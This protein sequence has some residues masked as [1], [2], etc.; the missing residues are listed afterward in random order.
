MKQ[1]QVLLVVLLVLVFNLQG[2]ADQANAA[3]KRGT[4]AEAQNEYEQAYDAYNQAHTLKPKDANYYAAYLRLRFYVAVQDVRDGQE[5][6]DAGKLQEALA[7]FNRAADV[8]ETNFYAKE[9]ARRTEEMIRRRQAARPDPASHPARFRPGRDRPAGALLQAGPGPLHRVRAADRRQ[10]GLGPRRGQ[11]LPRRRALPEEE[12]PRDL[13]QPLQA[14]ARDRAEEARRGGLAACARRQSSSASP[15]LRRMRIRCASSR[16]TQTCSSSSARS[17]R[18]ACTAVRS[19]DEGFVIDSPVLPHELEALPQVLEQSGFPVSGLLATHGD[20]DH[21]L[22]R[23]AFPEAS[24]G[25][26]REH[27]GAPGRRSASCLSASSP[28]STTST[29]SS[30]RPALALDQIQH[31]PVPGH[32]ALGA[33]GH[34]LE[35]HP[36]PGHTAD[37]TAYLIPWLGMLVCGDYLSPVEIP[38]ISAGGSAEAYLETLE[39]LQGL[40]PRAT[41]HRAGSRRPDRPRRRG[42]L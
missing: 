30:D 33:N 25:L 41:H 20:W 18:P 29:T 1:L 10:E 28:S 21:L 40:L 23:H 15:R 4:H 27:C 37:G 22:G 3:Y 5:L 36:A 34:E 32:L 17:G 38:W 14:A 35:L 39:R 31:L 13:G 8:D 24:L 26:R 16:S 9:E 6:R 42:A 12:D 2:Y 7:K 19:G 11:L